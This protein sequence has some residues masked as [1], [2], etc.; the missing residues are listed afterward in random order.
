MWA[1]F[2]GVEADIAEER[3]QFWIVAADIYKPRTMLLKNERM[4]LNPESEVISLITPFQIKGWQRKVHWFHCDLLPTKRMTTTRVIELSR[5]YL[6]FF[7]FLFWIKE[8]S[9]TAKCTHTKENNEN[10]H[11]KKCYSRELTFRDL[12]C[13]DN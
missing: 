8:S 12:S 2:H 3:L 9:T 11:K 1:L 4:L 5:T 13:P 7:F 10:C 6:I